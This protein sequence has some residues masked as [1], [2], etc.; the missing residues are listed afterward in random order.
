MKT[1]LLFFLLVILFCETLVAQDMSEKELITFLDSLNSNTYIAWEYQLD[2]LKVIGKINPKKEALFSFYNKTGLSS[3]DELI[4]RLGGVNMI[5]RGNY[6][7]EPVIRGLSGG[8]INV[9]IDGMKMLGACT[10]KMDPV[11]SYVEPQ[12]LESISIS[13]AK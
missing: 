8:Q 10:D 3:S 11:S 12:N 5:R 13:I 4:G 6:A 7:Y 2:E 1:A 9:T